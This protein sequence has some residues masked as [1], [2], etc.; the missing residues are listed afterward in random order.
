MAVKKVFYILMIGVMLATNW[1]AAAGLGKSVVQVDPGNTKLTGAVFIYRLTYSCDNTATDCFGAEIIDA[2]PPEVQYVSHVATSDVANVTVAGNLITFD[3]ID[4]LPA[5]NSGDLL[6]NVRFPNGSTPDGTVA[7]NTADGVNLETVPGT[8]TTPSVQV[9]AVASSTVNLSKTLQTPADLDLPTTYR[10]RLSNPSG[11]G[12]LNVS[13]ITVSDTLPAGVVYQG[14]V[15]SADCEPACIGTVAPA[16]TWTGPF[17]LNVGSN[18]DFNVTVLFPSATF[19][20]GQS[21]TNE[22]TAEGTPLNEPPANFGIGTITHPVTVFVADPDID[23]SKAVLSP[24]PPTLNQDFS[25]SMRIRNVG[26]VDLTNVVITDDLPIEFETISVS[27]GGYTNLTGTV[28]VN[29]QTN[30]SGGF[31]PLGTNSVTAN[32]TYN[33]P[34]L[35]VGEYVSNL[36]WVFSDDFPPGVDSNTRPLINGRIINPDNAGGVVSVGDS[37]QNCADATSV[38][39][40]SGVNQTINDLNNCPSFVISGPFVQL[41]PIKDELST[42]PYLPGDTINWRLRATN[43][44]RSSDA[45]PL[46]DLIITDLLPVDFIYTP[47]SNGYDDNGTGLPAP[48]FS[49]IENYNNTGRTLLNWSW[50]A[51][52]GN[53]DIN[54]DIRVTFDSTVRFGASF[55]NIDNTMGLTHNN[56]GL[57]LRC[58]NNNNGTAGSSA[59]IFDQDQ[60]G[61]TNDTLCQATN[62]AN[63][64]PVAQLSSSKEVKGVCDA[65]FT[66]T[67][68]GTLLGTPFEYRL[69]V[70]NQGTLT[71]E[72]FVFMD[73]LP[74]VGDTGVLDTNPRSSLWE[75]V[76]L[77]P[78]TPPPGTAIYYSTSGNPCRPEVGGITAGCDAPNWTTSPPSP[79]S[80]TK[81]FKVEFVDKDVLSFDTLQFELTMFAPANA[82]TGGQAAFNSFAYR[83]FRADGLGALSAEPNK[84]GM[85]IGSCPVLASLGDYVWLD[86]NINGL[87]DDGNTG[88]ND[89]YVQLFDDGVDGIPNTIDDRLVSTTVTSD[90]VGGNPGWYQFVTLPQDTYYVCFQ[91]PASYNITTQDVGFDEALDSDVSAVTLCT[92]PVFLPSNTNNPDLDLGLVGPLAGLGNY[93]WWDLNSDGVQN[94]PVDYGV[95]GVTVNLYADDGDG[96]PNPALDSLLVSKVTGNDLFDNPGY[97]EFG[98]LIPGVSYFV[99]F[100][101]PSPAT[102]F[103][104]INAGGDDVQDSDANVITG[105]TP[106]VVLSAGEFNP[107]IDAGLVVL[108]GN[109]SLG[110]QVWFEDQVNAIGVNNGIYD[111][112]FGEPGINAVDL[113]LYLDVN[114]NNQADINEY[115]TTTETQI[116]NGFEGR[117]LFNN[118]AP[119][120]YIVVVGSGN[121]AGN[122][123]LA[124]LTT[125]TANDPVTDP[126]DNFNGD[127]DGLQLGGVVVSLPITLSNGGEPIT[128]GDDDND[129]NLTVDFCFTPIDPMTVK[130]FDYGDDVDTGTGSSVNNYQTTALDGGAVHEISNVLNSPVLGLCVDADN[131][132]NQNANADADD[133]A[134]GGFTRGNCLADRDDEDGVV[135]SSQS[136]LPGDNISLNISAAAGFQAC[137]VNAWIDWNQNGL[138]ENTETVADQ[139]VV[140]PGTSVNVPVLV[141]ITVNPGRIYS[142]FRCN[143]VGSSLPASV[144]TASGPNL[145]FDAAPLG[146]VEDYVIQVIGQDLG[147]APD[148]YTTLLG[149]GGPSHL[150]D[151]NVP[152]FLGSCV[153]SEVDGAPSAG[154]GGDDSTAGNITVGLC[155][156]DE[157]GVVFN[158]NVNNELTACALNEVSV[159]ANQVGFLDAWVDL[160]GNGAFDVTDQIA[161]SMMLVPGTN[162]INFNIPCDAAVGNSHSRFR[163]STAGGLPVGGPAVDGEIED[164]VVI[165]NGIDMGD[166]P[167]AYP[168]TLANSGA[169]HG[170]STL[171]PMFLGSCVDTEADG[172]PSVDATADD[173]NNG[174]G[175]VGVCSGNDDEDGVLFTSPIAT[176]LTTDVTVTANVTGLLDAWF[177]FDNNGDWNDAGEK[178]FDGVNLAVG[179]N[180][181]QFTTPCNAVVG[182]ANLRFRFSTAGSVTPENGAIDGEVEDYQV[183]VLALDLGDNPDTYATLLANN[184]A[185]HLMDGTSGLFLGSCVDAE[186]DGQP[187]TG[188]DGDDTSA[189]S[190]IAGVCNGSDDEDGVIFNNGLTVCEDSDIT[191]TASAAGLLNAFVDFNADGSYGVGEQVF[192]DQALVAGPNNLTFNVP[193]TAAP[194][195]IYSRFRLSTAGG[196]A[197]AGL[198]LDGE[199]ED[200]VEIKGGSADLSISKSDD[201]DPIEAGGQLTYTITVDNL[202]PNDA[203][204]VVVT[205]NLP[206]GVS[207][208]STT[209]CAED[210]SGV[211]LC[212]LGNIAA[213]GSA[214]YTVTVDVDANLANNTVLTN[215][216]SV[217]SDTNDTDPGNDSTTEDTLVVRNSDLQITKTDSVDP[218]TAGQ[219]LTYFITVENLGPSDA[220][221]V[222]VTE[223]LPIDVTLVST[224]GCVED[225]TAVPNCSLGDLA[226]GNSV[227][228][229]VL[230]DVNPGFEGILNNTVEVNSDSS[231]SNSMNDTFTEP[232]IVGAAADLVISKVDDVDPAPPGTLLTYTVSVTNNGPSVAQ[233]VVVTDNLPAEVTFVS[234]AGCSEDPVGVPTCSLGNMNVGQTLSYQVVVNV[235]NNASGSITNTASVTSTTPDPDTNNNTT[236]E[237]TLVESADLSIT[238]VD[239]VDPVIAGDLLTYTIRVSN[240]GPTTADNV[241]V[242]DVLPTEVVLISTTGC[243][244]DPN[245]SPNCSLGSISPNQFADIQVVVRV[246]EQLLDGAVILNSASVTSSTSDP[247]PNNNDA[248]ENTLV[249]TQADLELVKEVLDENGDP[250]NFV[251]LF[252]GDPVRYRITVTNLGPSVSRNVVVTDTLP[253]DVTLV[254]TTGCAEDPSGVPDCGLGDLNFS[255]TSSYLV[256]V[257]IN[258]N[259]TGRISNTA[260]VSSDTTDPEPNN[261]L[262]TVS[263]IGLI[264]PVPV[265]NIWFLMLAILGVMGLSIIQLRR[266]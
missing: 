71:T 92:D 172:Q 175:V 162:S 111:P 120:N 225:P 218:A 104:L 53:L 47:A 203:S 169:S 36:Q 197:A 102:G 68:L 251:N 254:A 6:I 98:E 133:G 125:C 3:M 16:L 35:A 115:I 107:T 85:S 56:P 81:S 62:G 255:Q 119:G 158:S 206:A 39:D 139:L 166:A 57:G 91:P 244:E 193:C 213:N 142:R 231:D 55:G 252:P 26:N 77:A 150:I 28:T 199:V 109:L 75:P 4:P 50:P 250:T 210:P 33:I 110:N 216:A 234:T 29:F 130:F 180:S 100:I 209:G 165:I 46:E 211:N 24:N 253:A 51:A 223:T 66:T 256:D 132:L 65:N 219:P 232:T 44:P 37:V 70:V 265:N 14:S 200:Y 63:I 101:E 34:A 2:L 190:P 189:G 239:D 67:S 173:S 238:K 61:L 183:S 32:T 27:S 123:A 18:L 117:Y 171:S 108:N 246:D 262:Q 192:T 78:I 15:P 195:S 114:N 112:Q 178:I 84:V 137:F 191:I 157:D 257:T 259:A 1:Q 261:N 196:D 258:S 164:H 226:A 58:G 122:A 40:P 214:Q 227:Q 126:D 23:L 7:N 141:P 88:V 103:T 181:L 224:I 194:G 176:C 60:D 266:H 17:S 12:G 131:G 136:V 52:S 45:L 121:F 59:D 135:F 22:F 205:D 153:D 212:S 82:P 94:E 143:D 86:T 20:D 99:E 187:N 79:I 97:Y 147:D 241:V 113:D 10:L 247:D 161:S 230:V 74:F 38:Y 221:N 222:V 151:P 235:N 42:G 138:F 80:D 201:A 242:M 174:S 8:N 124:G 127:D 93:V 179:A 248:V 208:V 168:V 245:G 160:N 116:S 41:I 64:S 152:L 156:D 204:N 202:G 13:G 148:S 229:Q 163:F 260:D 11:F 49:V 264:T 54:D 228:Y 69:T 237:E 72:Q 30:L 186:L 48:N 96:I 76:L 73:I 95:N 21:V 19:I 184:G 188:S 144:Q 90:D 146:E 140:N 154:S 220:D 215:N 129:S 167:V 159:V 89:V 177:D 83:G 149:S 134:T 243:I 249:T 9:T 43:N 31:N 185:S 118:L 263:G 145:L 128:D 5:G 217:S 170:V 87:Q 155:F 106:I 25:Y 236:D 105:I 240:A 198:A 207:L 182:D 233:N